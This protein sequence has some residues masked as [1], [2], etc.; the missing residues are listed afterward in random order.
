M[1]G[2]Y[3]F[4]SFVCDRVASKCECPLIVTKQQDRRVHRHQAEECELVLQINCFLCSK[5]Q[6][7]ILCFTG[8][9]CHTPLLFGL[10]ETTLP[11][12]LSLKQ[13]PEV[14]LQ[15]FLSVAQSESEKPKSLRF[16]ERLYTR[17]RNS[18][19]LRNQRRCSDAH[20][21]ASLQFD[22]NCAKL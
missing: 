4:S 17:D 9:K 10:Q 20:Q 15:L 16:S 8:A 7:N 2:F 18:V 22:T 3:V 19:P 13:K 12:R 21:W 6:R 14:D 1:S 11:K 5:S